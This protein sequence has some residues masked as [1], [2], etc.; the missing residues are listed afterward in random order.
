MARYYNN[1]QTS[2]KSTNMRKIYERILAARCV[3]FSKRVIVID[4][5][6]D[7]KRNQ[8]AVGFWTTIKD[9]DDQIV[10][11]DQMTKTLQ[12]ERQEEVQKGRKFKA[13]NN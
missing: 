9:K 6:L 11:L 8:M 3:L 13:Q 10:Y 12:Y 2:K 5:A 7:K 1:F 4:A